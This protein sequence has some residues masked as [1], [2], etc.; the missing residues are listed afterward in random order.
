MSSLN[1]LILIWENITF[2]IV[3]IYLEW[4]AIY[5]TTGFWITVVLFKYG[6]LGF[7]EVCSWDPGGKCLIYF[8]VN[9]SRKL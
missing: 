8:M 1:D 9:G 3:M 4:F 2:V 7:R 5:T 6:A